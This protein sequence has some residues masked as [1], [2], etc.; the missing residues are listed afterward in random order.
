MAPI[1]FKCLIMLIV[2]L[3]CLFLSLY[4]SRFLV[5][6]KFVICIVIGVGGTAGNIFSAIL[7]KYYRDYKIYC[8]C[9]LLIACS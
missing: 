9:L 7:L 6:D 1:F 5:G 3:N 8:G 2:T 4:Q